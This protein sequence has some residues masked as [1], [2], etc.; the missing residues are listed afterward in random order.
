[1]SGEETEGRTGVRVP[2]GAPALVALL[3]SRPHATPVLPDTLDDPESAWRILGPFGLSGGEQV[4]DEQLDA[5]RALRS[6]LMTVVEGTD[7]EDTAR[8]W[9]AVTAT[10]ESVTFRHLFSGGEVALRQVTGHPLVGRIAAVVAR[11]VQDGTWSR[12]RICGNERCRAVFYD[13]TRSRT[14]RWHS[15][16]LCGNRANVAAYRAR[17]STSRTAAKP[18]S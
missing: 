4:S 1:M 17:K 7:E 10:V 8:G 14:Q 9:E 16:D 13:A 12:I 11:L 5:V 15:Y 18:V 3:N 2:D 6:A